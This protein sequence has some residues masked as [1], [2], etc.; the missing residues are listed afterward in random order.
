MT[1]EILASLVGSVL[2][3]VFSYTPGLKAKFDALSTD[4]KR[5][6]MGG[7]II[8]VSLVVFGVSCAGYGAQFGFAVACDADGAIGLTKIVVAAL[9][10][11]QATFQITKG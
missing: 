7:A 1:A 3:L 6:V 5:L 11:N 2:S 9:V 10:A 4:Y 8:A